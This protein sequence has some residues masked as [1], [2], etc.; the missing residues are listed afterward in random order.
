VKLVQDPL[1]IH[2]LLTPG[3]LLFFLRFSGRYFFF[4]SETRQSSWRLEPWW[5]VEGKGSEEGKKTDEKGERSKSE[6]D[7]GNVKGLRLATKTLT[8]SSALALGEKPK[9]TPKGLTVVGGLGRGGYGV[10]VSVVH[11]I[12]GRPRQFAMKCVSKSR[13]SDSNDKENLRRELRALTDIPPSPFLTTCYLAFESLSTVFFVTDLID[14]GD[15]FYHLDVMT[16]EGNDGFPEPQARI[17]LAETATGLCHMHDQHLIHCDIKVENIMLGADG[18]V[19]LVDYGLC[20][21]VREEDGAPMSPVG[22]LIYMAP[23]LLRESVGGRFTDWWALGVL[24]HELLT[25][26]SPWSTLSDK[27]QIKREIVGAP[28]ESPLEGMSLQA[29]DLVAAL[30]RKDRRAR[31]GYADSR[32]VLAHPFFSSKLNMGALE[33]G[34]TPPARI[35]AGA[36][37]AEVDKELELDRDEALEEYRTMERGKIADWGMKLTKVRQHPKCP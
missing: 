32:Q 18:H 30:M 29:S 20:C 14:G 23:E 35:S 13:S 10:V 6:E 31:L 9:L 8:I 4:N 19:K 21:E 37:A 11:Q 34:E 33:R 36:S 3:R 16:L 26:R 12:Q 25:G 28:V 5:D 27:K 7:D 24:A 15:L 1:K 22:S 17:I 2:S